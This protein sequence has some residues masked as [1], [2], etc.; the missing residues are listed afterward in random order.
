MFEEILRKAAEAL[1]SRPGPFPREPRAASKKS[2]SND[3]PR[4]ASDA[5]RALL[6]AVIEKLAGRVDSGIVAVE[7]TNEQWAAFE[8][9]VLGRTDVA[10]TTTPNRFSVWRRLVPETER[11]PVG[12]YSVQLH[13][14]TARVDDVPVRR[15]SISIYGS[16]GALL[17]DGA[18]PNREKVT[19]LEDR[20]VNLRRVFRQLWRAAFRV[21]RTAPKEDL[22]HLPAFVRN[23][24]QAVQKRK[25]ITLVI[26]KTGIA[27]MIACTGY[28]AWQFAHADHSIQAGVNIR[29]AADGRRG[30]AVMYWTDAKGQPTDRYVVYKDGR[31]YA[32]ITGSEAWV[33]RTQRYTWIDRAAM[34]PGQNHTFRLGKRVFPLRTVYVTPTLDLLPCWKCLMDAARVAH[35]QRTESAGGG[36]QHRA[37]AGVPFRFGGRLD[38][39]GIAPDPRRVVDAAKVE[40]DFGDGTPPAVLDSNNIVHTYVRPGSFTV[41]VRPLDTRYRT[42]APSIVTVGPGSDDLPLR[43]ELLTWSPPPTAD[44]TFRVVRAGLVGRET[45]IP[46][47]YWFSQLHRAVAGDYLEQMD[48]SVDYGDGSP[49]E[50]FPLS[51]HIS[52]HPNGSYSL[53]D[54]YI[55]H[56]WTKPGEYPVIL[57]TDNEPHEAYFM[58]VGSVM[59]CGPPDFR[60]H[61]VLVRQLDAT[62]L[63]LWYLRPKETDEYIT[64]SRG[65]KMTASLRPWTDLLSSYDFRTSD[66]SLL[67]NY[68]GNQAVAD[69]DL[70]LGPT[71]FMVDDGHS[72]VQFLL[73]DF[74]RQLCFIGETNVRITPKKEATPKARRDRPTELT[75]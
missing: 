37:I 55:E 44:G 18:T 75:P 26:T 42:P 58:G 1:S 68:G 14:A 48:V 6:R 32:E 40:V 67:V 69:D 54:P 23:F 9:A 15:L 30:V 31:E 59:I 72:W 8:A 3:Y 38:L 53:I 19:V 56:T 5:E 39:A 62:P 24:W 10:P 20:P 16:D 12:A 33:S 28:I 47:T 45:R 34:L 17:L 35:D 60:L 7:G 13:Y 61:D 70:E 21:L 43:S 50:T 46:L 52:K 64:T 73:A 63:E 29:A 4:S 25:R 71:S 57:H 36:K 27:I 22:Q 74:E 2:R 66:L 11:V 51:R 49:I 41:R 65:E